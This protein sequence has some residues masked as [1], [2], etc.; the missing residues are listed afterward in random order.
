TDLQSALAVANVGDEVWVA[1]GTYRPGPSGDRNAS[2]QLK[3][4][5]EVYGGFVGSETTRAQ[6]S[7]R[8]NPTILSGDID[9]NGA[10]DGNSY[11]VVRSNENDETAVLDGF[12]LTRGNADDNSSGPTGNGGGMFIA[13]GNPTL[14]NLR[15]VRN[16]A[17]ING[18]GIWVGSSSNPSVSNS[19]F[20]GNRV[21][22]FGDGGAVYAFNNESTFDNV[23]ISGNRADR[24]GAFALSSADVI[25][26]NTII[27]N[28]RDETGTGTARSSIVLFGSS[29]IISNSLVQGCNPGGIWNTGCG[30]NGGS[31]LVDANP[32]F[33]ETP[34]PPFDGVNSFGNLKLRAG[35]PAI[36]VGNNAV[37]SAAQDLSGN[38]RIVNNAVD[39]GAYERPAVDCS[40]GGPLFVNPGASEPSDG[41]SWS[42]AYS[43][44]QDALD[45]NQACTIWVAAGLYK[46]APDGVRSSS[47]RLRDDLAVFGGFSGNETALEQRDWRVNVTVLSGDLDNN[48]TTT[49]D[50]VVETFFLAI[51]RNA[52]NVV[53][54]SGVNSAATLDG[55]TITAGRGS[56]T[57]NDNRGAGIL[58]LGGLPALRNL[59]L[60]GNSAFTGAGMFNQNASPLMSNVS[61]VFNAATANGGGMHNL[62]GS[63]PLMV[64]ASFIANQAFIG[65]GMFNDNNSNPELHNAIFLGNAATNFGGGLANTAS[66]PSVTNVS[67]SGNTARD[68]F[69]GAIDNFDGSNLVLNNV[70]VWNN[71]DSTGIGNASSSISND[72]ATVMIGHSLLEGCRPGGSWQSACGTDMGSNVADAEPM[73]IDTPFP[74]LGFVTTEGDLRLMA[75]SPAIDVGNNSA[76]TQPV[77]LLGNDRIIN[78]TVDLGAYEFFVPP[79]MMFNDRFQAPP[80]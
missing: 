7:W 32:Q 14:T 62:D 71:R 48:D 17:L 66:S 25:I 38:R 35:S 23:T 11:S 33:L 69:G 40:G 24:G 59:R 27:W 47:F 68:F 16:Y 58:N 45:G 19:V 15:L 74:P 70:I 39:M 63:S 30:A 56:G 29:P 8:G 13:N 10:L 64:G 57:G 67:F 53:D 1:A 51:G 50:G 21:S 46:P 37:V 75:D 61:F 54:S 28:N 22:M 73:F 4:L 26:R 44:L 41:T 52:F 3:N 31:N 20:L 18:G 76:V 42:S 36:D 55:F 79:D 65:G 77:D 12:T 78:G 60:I 43:D 2:F 49:P 34:E 72:S 9:Q 80:P 6:R 5:V